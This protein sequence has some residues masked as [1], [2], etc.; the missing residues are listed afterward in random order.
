MISKAFMNHPDV[1][2]AN[3]KYGLMTSG[4]ILE[5]SS[6]MKHCNNGIGTFDELK[7]QGSDVRKYAGTIFDLMH[8]ICIRQVD[9]KNQVFYSR[10][11]VF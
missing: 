2:V 10:V 7:E 8:E 6:R 11:S 3:R 4:L 1:K 9:Y 5:I